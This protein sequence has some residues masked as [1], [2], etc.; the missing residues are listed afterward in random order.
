M[1]KYKVKEVADDFNV[2]SKKI[3]E[4][5]SDKCGVNKKSM[6]SLEVDELNMIFDVM[7]T[8]TALENFNDYFAVRD[9]AVEEYEK[10]VEEEIKEEKSKRK[11]IPVEKPAEK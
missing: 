10:Q 5:L 4:I 1:I 7:T 6:T 11:E 3:T 8:E 2:K 9:K